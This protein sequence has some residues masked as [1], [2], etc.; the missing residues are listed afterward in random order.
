MRL[1][2]KRNLFF[3]L[4]PV[5]AAW[6]RVHHLLPQR[7]LHLGRKYP[8]FLYLKC[9]DFVLFA[10]KDVLYQISSILTLSPSK[11]ITPG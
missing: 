5:A 3:E 4:F 8:Y 11:L 1:S 2:E 10:I 6:A 9:N 7:V